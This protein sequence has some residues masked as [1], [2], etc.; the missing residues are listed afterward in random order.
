MNRARLWALA[1]LAAFLALAGLAAWGMFGARVDRHASPLV[2]KPAPTVS[3][4]ALDGG[5]FDLAAFRG[6]PVIVNLFASWCGPCRVEHPYLMQLTKD[7]R[8]AL[9]G[10]AYRDEPAKTADFLEELG[11]PFDA[12]GIDRQGAAGVQLGLTGVPETYVIGPDGIILHKHAGEI[13]PKVAGELA[14]IAVKSARR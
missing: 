1:P 11:D 6:R 4:P 14:A 8:F 2:G 3:L 10:L 5:A 7:D 13:T 9:V 12:V